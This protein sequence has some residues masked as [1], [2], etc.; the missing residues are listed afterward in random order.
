MTLL[1]VIDRRSPPE[2]WTESD[3]IPWHEPG[4]SSRMLQ[5]HLTQEHN[6]ASRRFDIID[7]QV[8]WIEKEILTGG[9]RRI[10]ELACGPGF[11]LNRLASLGHTCEGIDYSPASIDYA[12]DQARESG[13]D[14]GYRLEDIRTA[15]FGQGFDLIM[16]IYGEFNVFPASVARSI[17]RK[18]HDALVDGGVL[19][20]EPHRFEAVRETGH[21]L[22]SWYSAPSGLFSE[23][24]HIA[25]S[26]SFWDD[27]HSTATARYL[28]VDANTGDVETHS[29]SYRAYTDA[30]YTDLL[31]GCG[32]SQIDRHESLEGCATD[33]AEELTV[34]A[35]RKQP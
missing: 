33:Y 6:A 11:Y 14:I 27:D 22:R 29:A 1:D 19:L 32:F 35:A 17:I 25:L 12:R 24:P 15:A 23:G 3:N 34:F 9:N 2:P 20:L 16:L 26:E 8:A 30:E 31:E 10:L 7:R 5:E 21:A 28:I 4:F 13:L 18:A